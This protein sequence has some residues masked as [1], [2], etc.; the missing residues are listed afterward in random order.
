MRK[1]EDVSKTMIHP[2]FDSLYSILYLSYIY[3]SSDEDDD[4]L[5]LP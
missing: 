4:S 3:S 5:K 1:K 2:L